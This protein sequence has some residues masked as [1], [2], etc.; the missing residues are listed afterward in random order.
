[1]C[2]FNVA[3]QRILE[4]CG[5]TKEGFIRQGKMINTWCDYYVY[6]ILD[7]DYSERK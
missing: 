7:S 5:Y 4:K 3:S 1:M 2:R 6:G